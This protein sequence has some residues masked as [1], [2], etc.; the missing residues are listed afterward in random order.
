MRTLKSICYE[1]KIDELNFTI[2]PN[3]RIVSRTCNELIQ[4]RIKTLQV[5]RYKQQT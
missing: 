3:Q 5:K 2:I 1:R 4:L